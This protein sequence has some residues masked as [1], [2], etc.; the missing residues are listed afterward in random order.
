MAPSEKFIIS[1]IKT[2]IEEI[3]GG[4]DR[5]KL[6]TVRYVR[7]VVEEDLGLVKGFLSEEDWKTKSKA[8]I[9]EYAVRFIVLTSNL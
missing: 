5:E 8:L 9:K 3:F 2:K 4:P 7:D 1:T 6:L